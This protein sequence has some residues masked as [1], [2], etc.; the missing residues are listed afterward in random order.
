LIESL[1]DAL[2]MHNRRL[3]QSTISYLTHATNFEV[4]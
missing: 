4:K 1:Y 3:A 2:L